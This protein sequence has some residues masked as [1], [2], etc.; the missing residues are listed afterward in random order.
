[1]YINPVLFGII[2]TLLVEIGI[3]LIWSGIKGG[4][5]DEDSDNKGNK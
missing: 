3:I 4:K 5:K 2:M 1:M